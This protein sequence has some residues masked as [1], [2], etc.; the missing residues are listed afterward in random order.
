MRNCAWRSSVILNV[1][2]GVTS[3]NN[4]VIACDMPNIDICLVQKML[5]D[6]K[7]FDGIVPRLG[8]DRYEPLFAVYTKKMLPI[9]NDLLASG[10]RKIDR[11]YDL[12]KMEYIDL[13]RDLD[14]INTMQDYLELSGGEYEIAI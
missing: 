10:E 9:I 6:I 2:Y 3:K 11:T 13:S 8:K 7:S 14:N 12:C 4:F 5:R 1:P